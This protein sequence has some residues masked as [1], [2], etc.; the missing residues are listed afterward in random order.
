MNKTKLKRLE[1]V[2]A[3]EEVETAMKHFVPRF[4]NEIDMIILE[5]LSLMSFAISARCVARALL[6]CGTKNTCHILS[7]LI[8]FFLNTSPSLWFHSNSPAFHVRSYSV[9]SFFIICSW[10]M[11]L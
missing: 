4:G 1:S 6:S 3:G 2:R 10:V 7:G 5:S 11:V 9:W 8:G